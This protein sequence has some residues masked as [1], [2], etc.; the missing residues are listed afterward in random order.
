MAQILSI[1]TDLLN[2]L[3]P[4]E[5]LAE[6]FP[7]LL[8]FL[9]AVAIALLLGQITPKIIESLVRILSPEPVFE[10]YQTLVTPVQSLFRTVASFVF[11]EVAWNVW[12]DYRL[13]YNF[14]QPFLGLAT[15]ISMAW[16]IS[17]VFRQ[18]FRKYGINVLNP[19]GKGSDEIAMV[20]ET[21]VNII[22]GLVAA[23][24]FAQSQNF[25]LIGLLASLGIG[26]LAI[27]FA[28]QKILEQLLSTI[29]LYLDKPFMPGDYIRLSGAGELG[30][31]ESIGLRSTKVRISG[32]STLLVIP[33]SDLINTRI[34]N[35]TRAKKVMVM[36]Y[37]D[38][39]KP[40]QDQ[41]GALVS[42]IIK[43]STNSLL[44]IDPGS[45]SIA[46]LRNERGSLDR[47]RVTFFILGS[48]DGSVEFRKQLLALANE[49]ISK[50]LEGFGITVAMEDPVAYVD[51]PVTV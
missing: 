40:L 29:V 42:Q 35:V 38:F 24:A 4:R 20:L 19:Q 9:I 26:G 1:L 5:S 45:T 27:A 3:I 37:M 25:N 28:A 48:G 34:E 2:Q 23:V 11:L 10:I 22:I 7:L 49:R 12:Q 6:L 32:K 43:D 51:S 41:E 33:N 36:L 30:R 31:V 14:T 47:A 39:A 21:I 15:A 18:F 16:F 44:G 13:V 17:R 50:Q 8:R 46:L